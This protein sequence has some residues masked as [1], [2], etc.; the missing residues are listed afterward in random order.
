MGELVIRNMDDQIIEQLKAKAVA[1]SRSLEQFLCDILAEAVRPTRES[2]ASNRDIQDKPTVAQTDW[3]SP[4]ARNAR[5]AILQQI[6][7][8]TPQ[9]LSGTQWPSIE[10]LIREDR[11]NNEAYR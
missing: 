9:T 8:M 11:D 10:S 7:A 1:Q 3:N 5:L 2:L 4:T 6:R